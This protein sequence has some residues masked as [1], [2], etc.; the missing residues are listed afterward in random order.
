MKTESGAADSLP[1][2]NSERFSP[3]TSLGIFA[4]RRER[5]VGIRSTILIGPFV[6]LLPGI[7]PGNL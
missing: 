5:I 7:L 3:S 2:T 4:S 1:Q 6:V